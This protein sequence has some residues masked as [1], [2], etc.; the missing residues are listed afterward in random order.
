MADVIAKVY[1]VKLIEV[2]TGFKYIG[3]QI[4]FFEQSGSNNYV[5]GLEAFDASVLDDSD[6]DGM[7]V[8]LPLLPSLDSYK[9]VQQTIVLS[10]DGSTH[11]DSFSSPVSIG[12]SLQVG[13]KVDVSLN[14]AFG[15]TV[16][17]CVGG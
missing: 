7:W 17:V 15:A 1:D 5:F 6:Y 3:E 8:T 11:N 14:I 13:S 4:K 12:T 2:L 16:T 10:V 9:N